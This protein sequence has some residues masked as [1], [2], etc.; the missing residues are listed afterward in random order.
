MLKDKRIKKISFQLSSRI[1]QILELLSSGLTAKEIA[2]ELGT[3][4]QTIQKQIK[5]TKA[6]TGITTASL[7]ALYLKE[8]FRRR[9]DGTKAF[10][11]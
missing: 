8:D 5:N 1:I 11:A 3:S 9:E 4:Y 10:F 2:I 6:R 7:I